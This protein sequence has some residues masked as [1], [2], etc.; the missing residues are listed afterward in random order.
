MYISFIR[1]I[2][3]IITFMKNI[4]ILEVNGIFLIGTKLKVAIYISVLF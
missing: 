4:L 3:E 2:T 1:R